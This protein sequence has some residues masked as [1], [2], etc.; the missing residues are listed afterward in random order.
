MQKSHSNGR[1]YSERGSVDRQ[2]FA[3]AEAISIMWGVMIAHYG[4]LWSAG[5]GQAI[6]GDGRLTE[7][8][9]VWARLL[10]GFSNCEI[11]RGVVSA[12]MQAPDGNPPSA[13]TI[14][15]HASMSAGWPHPDNALCEALNASYAEGGWDQYL[16]SHPAVYTAAV[17]VGRRSIRNASFREEWNR[18]WR[19]LVAGDIDLIIPPE[20][21][22]SDASTTENISFDDAKDRFKHLQSILD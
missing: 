1:V 11:E 7:T 18:V 17:V 16:W 15:L 20:P 4:R 13:S 12:I 6:G 19:R 21:K 9:I 5:R 3:S 8:G 14:R 10:G 22:V 2:E